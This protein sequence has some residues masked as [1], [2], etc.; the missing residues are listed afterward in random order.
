MHAV[1]SNSWKVFSVDVLG[2]RVSSVAPKYTSGVSP[3]LVVAVP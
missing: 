1:A 2:V 3:R